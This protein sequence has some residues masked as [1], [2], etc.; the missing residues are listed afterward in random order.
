[1][2]MKKFKDWKIMSKIMTITVITM[3]LILSG[4]LL[5]LMPFF[6]Q[7]M[8]D[9]K[10]HKVKNL[11]ESV[12]S[13]VS[14]QHQLIGEGGLTEAQAQENA[15]K[16]ISEIRYDGREYFWINDSHPRMVM[17]PISPE[18]N[19]TDLSDNR[20]PNG[21]ALFVEMKNVAEQN[22]EGYVDYM[23]RKPDTQVVAPK[24]SYV[25]L[26]R[27]WGWIIGTG[28][29]V[30]DVDA[31]AAAL[32]G[33]IM[34]VLM[35][36]V[37]LVLLM[38][39]FIARRISDPLE[40]AV[41]VSNR[42]A[43]GDLTT[44]IESQ[45]QDETGQLQAAMKNMLEKLKEVF[46]NV[47]QSTDNVTAGSLELSRASQQISQGATEQAASAE[48]A[49]SSMEEMASNIRQNADNAL[50]TEKISIKAA[51][52]A[53]DGGQAVHETVQAMRDIAEKINIIEEIS[54]QTNLLALNAAIEAAR[55]GE[56]GK[57]FAVV[58]SEVRKL[59]E[60]SQV[61]AAE[62]SGLSSSS[63]KVA[64][65]A[66]E[67][68]KKIV[69]DIQKTA[70][71]VEE[72]STAS[73]E[74]TTGAQQINQAI[75]QLDQVIQQNASA[76]EELAST[77]EEMSGLAEHLQSVISFFKLGNDSHRSVMRNTITQSTPTMPAKISSGGNGSMGRKASASMVVKGSE[78][79]GNGNGK[80]L[81]IVLS[82]EEDAEFIA[83]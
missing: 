51:E 74:Q 27:P 63:I 31:Q 7:R 72:I 61:A 75:Q 47:K 34:G 55:A 79:R 69:P 32:Q 14:A 58:A 37:V 53:R 77:A 73:N 50:Q 38:A 59:A 28:I 21:K 43:E 18:L 3:V 52:D 36:M 64:E 80:G 49:S 22:G 1:M 82:E 20:D 16:L 68:L 45:S 9:E 35:V 8:M 33:A 65:K 15:L 67:L 71:L 4:T 70:E 26:F 60:R 2:K 12:Y 78:N 10:Q 13:I 5:Y 24:E 62:I 48:E 19:G 66:G 57:G 29:W 42:L 40:E 30:D 23:W 54:R 81:N 41:R 11:V 46:T 17:H 83:F 76:S 6:K 44:N 56:N 39:Y 25:K